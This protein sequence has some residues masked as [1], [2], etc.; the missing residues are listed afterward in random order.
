MSVSL[1]DSFILIKLAILDLDKRSFRGPYPVKYKTGT[2]LRDFINKIAPWIN[3]KKICFF[4]NLSNSPVESIEYIYSRW[5]HVLVVTDIFANNKDELIAHLNDKTKERVCSFLSSDSDNLLETSISIKKVEGRVLVQSE[6]EEAFKGIISFKREKDCISF[7]YHTKREIRMIK[8]CKG[9]M[10]KHTVS[11]FTDVASKK[12]N[13]S[14][15]SILSAAKAKDAIVV[16]HQK[17]GKTELKTFL[18]ESDS[19]FEYR[20]SGNRVNLMS[21]PELY[22][23]VSLRFALSI[24]P[25]KDPWIQS[26]FSK[27]SDLIHRL[28]TSKAIKPYA[29]F[30]LDEGEYAIASYRDNKVSLYHFKEVEC[31]CKQLLEFA[32]TSPPN[33]IV[34]LKTMGAFLISFANEPAIY[35]IEPYVGER[36]NVENLFNPDVK[37]FSAYGPIQDMM[38]IESTTNME[39]IVLCQE[40]RITYH[41]IK[42]IGGHNDF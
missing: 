40:K 11:I 29:I 31:T 39:I 5:C 38:V 8:A 25:P 12:N 28:Y 26:S 42:G 4:S 2:P 41:I 13:F 35:L 21:L 34:Y 15:E 18:P 32:Y 22:K 37:D 23:G 24:T 6:T 7:Y 14:C 27:A 1:R 3:A 9:N 33:Y 19:E 17:G 36:R 16:E 20:D 10:E 30:R